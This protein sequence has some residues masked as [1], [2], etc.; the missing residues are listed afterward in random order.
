MDGLEDLFADNCA[1][2][3][4][5]TADDP[6]FFTRLAR[7]QAP[8]YRRDRAE[9]T[10]RRGHASVC[11]ASDPPGRM[12]IRHSRGVHGS[13]QVPAM[14]L[15][16]PEPTNCTPIQISRK[17]IIRVAAFM[18]SWPIS[19]ETYCAECSVSQI[20]THVATML[21]TVAA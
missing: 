8:R 19:R 6:E 10:A 12:T 7:Q 18:P 13:R 4:Q 9:D 20:T 3:A 17:P 5:R 1:W 16:M 14:K 2:S 11:A 15:R 21:P